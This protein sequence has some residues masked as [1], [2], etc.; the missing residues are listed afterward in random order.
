M[1]RLTF[2][3]WLEHMDRLSSA[4]SGAGEIWSSTGEYSR[5]GIRSP[6]IAPDGSV[7]EPKRVNP[8]E[9]FGKKRCKK[10]PKSINNQ[11]L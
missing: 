6:N 3:Q 7:E 4:P 8:E 11:G 10:K 1:D 5:K 9:L 2:T